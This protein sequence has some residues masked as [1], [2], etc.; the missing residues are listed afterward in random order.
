[1]LRVKKSRSE[2]HPPPPA[3]T[4]DPTGIAQE[5]PSLQHSADEGDNSRGTASRLPAQKKLLPASVMTDTLTPWSARGSGSPSFNTKSSPTLAKMQLGGEIA[6]HVGA[7]LSIV[8]GAV[9]SSTLLAS[10]YVGTGSQVTY[11]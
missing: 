11:Q 3:S 10:G 5:H 7:R 8:D 6:V 9:R 1:M 4:L 2:G